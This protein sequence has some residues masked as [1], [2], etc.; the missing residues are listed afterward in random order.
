VAADASSASD[1]AR[2]EASFNFPQVLLSGVADFD[3]QSL[4][5]AGIVTGSAIVVKML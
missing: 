2:F 3:M 1:G 5:S 4:Q